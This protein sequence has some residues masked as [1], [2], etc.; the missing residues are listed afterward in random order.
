MKLFQKVLYGN[1]MAF[2]WTKI[3]RTA[4]AIPFI[5]IPAIAPLRLYA[6]VP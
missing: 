4:E 5:F 6:F 3:K 1:Y 2:T